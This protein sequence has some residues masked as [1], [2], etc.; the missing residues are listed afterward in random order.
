MEYREN[1]NNSVDAGRRK[2]LKTAGFF[3]LA[4]IAGGALRKIDAASDAATK[5][6]GSFTS[7]QQQQRIKRRV[8]F[9]QENCSVHKQAELL[10]A[11][12]KVDIEPCNLC[13]EA[14]PIKPE[15]AIIA[16][17]VKENSKLKMPKL[18]EEKCIGC[19]R[20]L[21]VCPQTP[22]AWELWDLTNNKKLM[23]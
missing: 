5:A 23:P 20:C 3:T 9:L 2:M 13:I 8:K 14:C 18:I 16:V 19:G 11:K 21:R 22:K 17:D 1:I 10:K 6:A 15:K 4:L 12:K 7:P